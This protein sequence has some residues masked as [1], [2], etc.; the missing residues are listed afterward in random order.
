MGVGAIYSAAMYIRAFR[1][2]GHT[3]LRLVESYRDE[4]GRAR[5]RQIAQLGCVDQVG[6][7]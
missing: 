3:Y 7:S 6:E 1:S 5:Q 2:G 4:A